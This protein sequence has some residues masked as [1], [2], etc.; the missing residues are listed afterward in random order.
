MTLGSG[1]TGGGSSGGRSE[2]NTYSARWL[3]A[4][5]GRNMFIDGGT[6]TL[7]RFFPTPH[8]RQQLAC[9]LLLVCTLEGYFVFG[10]LLA[11][12]MCGFEGQ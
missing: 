10:R 9:F 12:L 7:V 3:V 5:F 2:G 6:T 1:D 8:L 4:E 11:V